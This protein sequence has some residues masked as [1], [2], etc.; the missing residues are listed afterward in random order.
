[1]R[2]FALLLFLIG[3]IFAIVGYTKMTMKCPPPQIEYRFVPR[4]F[5]DEQLS[6]DGSEAVRKLFTDVDPFTANTSPP[7]SSNNSTEDNRTSK[8]FYSMEQV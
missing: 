1:M 3:L 4:T 6:G 5:L 7:S 8:N 2:T